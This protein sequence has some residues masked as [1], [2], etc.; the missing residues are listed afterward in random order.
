MKNWYKKLEYIV[1]VYGYIK[2]NSK[3]FYFDNLI[4][5]GG[6]NWCVVGRDNSG[7]S[8]VWRTISS[9]INSINDMFTHLTFYR[10]VGYI[11]HVIGGLQLR[12]R[13]SVTEKGI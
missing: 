13:N 6:V 12:N 2:Q 4:M 8:V 9:R 7:N 10:G 11:R 1:V 5:G 3:K